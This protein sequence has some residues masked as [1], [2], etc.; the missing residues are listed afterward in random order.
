[1]ITV[2]AVYYS[3]FIIIEKEATREDQ[4]INVVNM[5]SYSVFIVS[6]S[7]HPAWCEH[8]PSFIFHYKIDWR[9]LDIEL[10]VPV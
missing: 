1:M 10:G 7:N 2:V 5:Y 4:G 6:I 9:N 3:I 8:F